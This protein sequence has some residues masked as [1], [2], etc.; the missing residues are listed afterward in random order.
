MWTVLKLPELIRSDFICSGILEIA[1]FRQNQLSFRLYNFNMSHS[2]TTLKWDKW[3]C[4]G[5]FENLL[6]FDQKNF[7]VA[8]DVGYVRTLVTKVTSSSPTRMSPRQREVVKC[9]TLSC[10]LLDSICWHRKNSLK[11]SLSK[12]FP[13]R[14]PFFS[15]AS[16]KI[17]PD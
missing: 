8:I 11:H 7:E 9:V 6:I 15:R 14:I 1:Y 12:I 3:N 5:D 16:P 17:H 4:I 13:H 10:Y 2:T